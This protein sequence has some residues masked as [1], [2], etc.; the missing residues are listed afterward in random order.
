[1][2]GSDFGPYRATALWNEAVILFR[3]NMP[4]QEHR[5]R[6][7]KHRNSFTG[8]EGVS[9]IHNA[10]Q[11]NPLFN[12]HVSREQACQLL[13]QFLKADLITPVRNCS[14]NY[15][16][17][18]FHD[19]HRHL[20]EFTEHLLQFQRL[21]PIS[22]KSCLEKFTP[23]VETKDSVNKE[24]F[25][26]DKS[27]VENTWKS[28]VLK[29]IIELL[30][31]FDASE[32]MNIQEINPKW[33]VTNASPEWSKIKWNT[34][35]PHWILSTMQHLLKYSSKDYCG[36]AY[37]HFHIDAFKVISD[38]FKT[39]EHPIIL[40]SFY[41]LYIEIF[42]YLKYLNNIETL[43]NAEVKMSVSQEDLIF[44]ISS[45]QK[46]KTKHN[47]KLPNND[48]PPNHC[49]EA[50]FISDDPTIR[51]VP[52]RSVDS[53]HLQKGNTLQL[54]KTD[55]S[56]NNNKKNEAL[57]ETNKKPF[58]N[59][60]KIPLKTIDN[61]IQSKYMNEH[62]TGIVNEAFAIFSPMKPKGKEN[63]FDFIKYKSD[64]CL[65][66]SRIF[67]G[68][69]NSHSS[70]GYVNHG[71]SSSLEDMNLLAN[72]RLDYDYALKSLEKLMKVSQYN[73]SSS[74]DEYS[75]H[76]ALSYSEAGISDVECFQ[77]SENQFTDEDDWNHQIL[78]LG[79]TV[80]QLLLM[81]LPPCNRA[82]LKNISVLMYELS[83][84]CSLPGLSFQSMLME[85]NKSILRPANDEFYYDTTVVNK[86]LLFIVDNHNEIFTELS[87]EL[88]SA[89]TNEV[90]EQQLQV[91]SFCKQITEKEFEA[92]RTD[93][94]NNALN[95][96]LDHIIN[97]NGI[98]EKERKKHLK[99]FKELYPA[100]YRKRFPSEI[101]A[102]KTKVFFSLK[103]F[104]L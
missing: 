39:L 7:H 12:P 14:I 15:D 76:T 22:I 26:S 5:H 11:S 93:E 29:R 41:R 70:F 27:S 78:Y 101:C 90:Y 66:S 49:Y 95:Q 69:D 10:L 71:L 89:I 24:N 64:D 68:V 102:S 20:Y 103:N 63:S 77:D 40:E 9:F 99:V 59:Y 4:L 83:R 44:S 17:S 1:M 46:K 82:Q 33:I 61:C 51:V 98:S 38:Y 32:I 88:L 91:L 57:P 87:S 21:K 30:Q 36:R 75:F 37:P 58:F 50:A 74:D 52:Q 47:I 45:P 8:H 79:I 92:Q 54:K 42:K 62:K 96:L 23:D 13:K 3:D 16:K 53:V 86:I 73:Q 34:E 31:P 80:F 84:N 56:L 67:C 104:R 85:L 65:N 100:I 19:S 81:L 72:D 28:A 55:Q 48:L 97:N 60:R 18:S 43:K 35:L 2:N 6:L 94:S 25:M